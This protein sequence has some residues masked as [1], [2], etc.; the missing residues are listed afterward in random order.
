MLHGPLNV[1]ATLDI[2]GLGPHTSDPVPVQWQWYYH[3]PSFAGWA[4]IVALLLLVREN[5]NRQAWLILIPFLL[6]SEILWPWTERILAMLSQRVD[7]DG[8]PLLWLI[9]V[10]TAVW[11]TSPW[12]IRRRPAIAFVLVLA[13]AVIVGIGTEFGLHQYMYVNEL[14]IFYFVGLYVSQT[15][16]LIG[17]LALLLAFTLSAFCCRRTYRPRRFLVWL[18]LWLLVAV[19]VGVT[20]EVVWMASK[21]GRFDI[22]PSRLP[23]IGLATLRTATALYL[24]NLPFVILAFRCPMYR[25]RFHKLLRLP[26]CVPDATPPSD[27]CLESNH[28]R[29]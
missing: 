24:L 15:T 12:L 19:A 6:L 23:Q 29:S 4:L 25:D 26:E 21:Y 13:S 5:R 11:L 8:L 3:L 20:C 16:Y 17:I 18:A 9:V 22:L 1:V 2:G 7:R 27:A 28:Q 14:Q 10:W